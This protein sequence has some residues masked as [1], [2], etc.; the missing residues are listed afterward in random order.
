MDDR[1]VD[2]FLWQN[3]IQRGWERNQYLQQI[4]NLSQVL[5]TVVLQNCLRKTERVQ[6]VS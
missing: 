3:L 2:S 1:R 4:P 5:C 6:F